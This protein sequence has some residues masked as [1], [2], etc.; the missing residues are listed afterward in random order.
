MHPKGEPHSPIRQAKPL[1]PAGLIS[2]V[3]CDA[4]LG[5]ALA[6][7]KSGGLPE[8]LGRRPRLATW[9]I[10][11][12][13]ELVDSTWG[14]SAPAIEL[15]KSRVAEI[16]LGWLMGQL[17]PDGSALNCII[18]ANAWLYRTSWRPFL[19]LAC[20]HGLLEVPQIPGRH[21]GLQSDP[22]VDRLCAL[23]DVGSSTY[24][25]Y[26]EK[27][28]RKMV[29]L[30]IQ[31]PFGSEQ[32]DSL[33]HHVVEMLGSALVFSQDTRRT[34][35]HQQAS[36][37]VTHSLVGA[38]AWHYIQFE[39][40]GAVIQLLKTFATELAANDDVLALLGR[41]PGEGTSAEQLVGLLLARAALARIRQEDEVE[42][43]LLERALGA[44]RGNGRL[45][46]QVL[47]GVGDFYQ[48]RNLDRALACYQESLDLSAATANQI[49][50]FEQVD[51]LYI[52]SMS[53]LGW[54]YV[55]RNDPRAL[56]VLQAATACSAKSALPSR[57]KAA[58]ELSWGEYW[59]RAGDS[60]KELEH[61]HRALIISEAVGD[62]REVLSVCNNLSIS[63]SRLGRFER[64][65]EYSD[66]VVSM[67][68]SGKVEATLLAAA[69]GNKGAALFYLERYD[70]AISSY[71][72]ALDVSTRANL[73]VQI[74]RQQFNLA[75]AY[76]KRYAQQGR[77]DDLEAGE[78]YALGVR[79]SKSGEV[80]VYLREAATQLKDMMLGAG[81]AFSLTKLVPDEHAAHA[82]HMAEIQ[83]Q[84][85]ALT[86]S[87]SPEERVKAHLSIAQAYMA[88]A[89]DE[90]EAAIAMMQKHGLFQRFAG[91]LTALRATFDR[92]QTEEQRVQGEWR[93]RAG[94]ML[95]EQRRIAVLEHLFS[96]GS[97][98][99]STYARICGVG[100]ATASKHL[101]ALT[102][103]GLLTQTGKG[104]STRY[105]L[106]SVEV[107]PF[108][109]H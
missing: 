21:S 53:R 10:R 44:A 66:R 96:D 22:P 101:V 30:L 2:A 87:R 79:D 12:V 81:E 65:I 11:S 4:I 33:R 73:M 82:A 72:Q 109:K 86:V 95:E 17:R 23:W 70:D 76:Y 40:W 67:G 42:Q 85:E 18:H 61:K 1:L 27:G 105:M 55:L 13:Y 88:I 19:A 69:L 104:P 108:P 74:S 14:Q 50:A 48:S 93:L 91:E 28:R 9:L 20:H 16:T 34:W 94:E 68:A 46:A 71:G 83:R 97:I 99:K 107:A 15:R 6:A 59:G 43:Q 54:A 100:P 90:R 77:P 103:L 41:L 78:R 98:Q 45:E 39:D 25:R 29:G 38:A 58:L 51:D 5:A 64:S 80:D 84:R 52:L 102:Q 62:L 24:Y 49:D 47:I 63:Y 37:A 31:R 7:L 26:V 3:A 89:T 106:T 75:E 32:R 57:S 56:A 92:G 35:H 36:W 8:L 60:G